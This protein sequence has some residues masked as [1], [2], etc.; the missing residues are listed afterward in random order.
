MYNLTEYSQNYLKRSGGLRQ[1]CNVT[2]NNNGDVVDFNEANVIDSFNFK[3]KITGQTEDNAAEVV[4]IVVPLKCLSNFR[5]IIEMSLINCEVNP[6]LSWSVTCVIVSTNVEGQGAT[7]LIIGTKLYVPV[8]TSSTQD[9]SRLLQHL[10][11]SFKRIINWNKYQSNSEL[12][13]KK[14]QLE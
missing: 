5:R 2:V 13:R 8:V 6:N 10:K 3:E 12:L 4:E 1:Y 9:N 11:S 14:Q 7:F